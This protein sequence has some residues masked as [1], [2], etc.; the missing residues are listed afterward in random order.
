MREAPDAFAP[1]ASLPGDK[2]LISG[3]GKKNSLVVLDV[4]SCDRR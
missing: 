4:Q 2:P 1:E 3:S